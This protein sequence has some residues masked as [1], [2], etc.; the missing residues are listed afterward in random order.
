MYDGVS[1]PLL[2]GDIEKRYRGEIPARRPQFVQAAPDILGG[3]RDTQGY[4][5]KQMEGYVPKSLP[6]IDGV[7]ASAHFANT[8]VGVTAKMTRIVRAAGVSLQS[9]VLLAWGKT[10][11]TLLG[12]LDVAFGQVVAG[13]S[14]PIEDALLA[15]G[16][17]F[18]YVF[19]SLIGIANK[20]QYN[21]LQI[22]IEEG[23][24]ERT[25]PPRTIC[26]IQ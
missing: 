17:L 2:L 1:L 25:S 19:V 8:T 21:P 22:Q 20:L 3:A 16:P 14:I 15:S 9:L 23:Y 5:Q 6:R 24:D 7:K 11:S 26:A 13:R 10:L 4:W 18:K 12:S